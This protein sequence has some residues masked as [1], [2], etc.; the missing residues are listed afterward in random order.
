VTFQIGRTVRAFGGYSQDKSGSSTDPVNRV[1]FGLSSSNLLKTGLDIT[2]S[3]YRYSGG[4]SPSYDSWYVSVGRNLSPRV[5]L[6]GEYTSSL[7]VLRYVQSSGIIIENRP[8]TKRFG[9]TAIVHMGRKASLLVVFDHTQDTNYR[10]NRVL[11]GLN[12][13]F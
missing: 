6:S 9:G 13:R 11:A 2:V 12:F 4:T 7:S 10:D 8:S 3:D 1:S 5:Y